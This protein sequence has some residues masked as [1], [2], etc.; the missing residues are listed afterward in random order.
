M[1]YK[2]IASQFGNEM[3]YGG[4]LTSIDSA[5]SSLTD[6]KCVDHPLEFITSAR[7][8]R[9]YN[10]I[11]TIGESKLSEHEKIDMISQA[12]DDLVFDQE[13]KD[14]LRNLL[15]SSSSPITAAGYKHFDIPLRVY[16]DD[17]D[18]FLKSDIYQQ[19]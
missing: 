9:T 10:W 8:Q 16:V 18:S 17:V 3:R 4:T 11:M 19:K 7:Y 1:N 6:L 5:F 15:A 12:I 13:S 2:R 14:R